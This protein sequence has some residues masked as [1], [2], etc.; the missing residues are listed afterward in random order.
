[1]TKRVGYCFAVQ[2][3]RLDFIYVDVSI[4]VRF[5]SV[6]VIAVPLMA[7]VHH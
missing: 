3:C 2:P 1:M 7:N 5:R 4:L 6:S